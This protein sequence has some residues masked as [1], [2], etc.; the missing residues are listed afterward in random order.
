MSW[1]V[2]RQTDGMRC[3]AS[4][5]ICQAVHQLQN[6]ESNLWK[7]AFGVT[8]LVTI[9]DS[10]HPLPSFVI[11]QTCWWNVHYCRP[12]S[13]VRSLRLSITDLLSLSYLTHQSPATT[14]IRIMKCSL[15]LESQLCGLDRFT[16]SCFVKFECESSLSSLQRKDPFLQAIPP[17]Y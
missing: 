4:H 15:K 10:G 16:T 1:K 7:W 5:A 6:W 14:I 17:L 12:T 3:V 9:S 13:C 11:S 8:L 2:D